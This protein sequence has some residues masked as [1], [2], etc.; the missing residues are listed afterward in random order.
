MACGTLRILSLKIKPY[1]RVQKS[2]DISIIVGKELIRQ[3]KENQELFNFRSPDVPPLLL[4]IDRKDDPVTPLLTQWTYQAMVHEMLGIENNLVDLSKITSAEKKLEQPQIV[5]SAEQDSFYKENMFN[6]FGDLGTSIRN[7]VEQYQIKTKQQT[8]DNKDDMTIEE[9][10]TF[11]KNIP[12]I[13]KL[14]GNVTKHMALIEELQRQVKIRKLL[15]VSELEQQLA[16]V[17]NHKNAVAHLNTMFSRSGEKKINPNELLKLVLLYVLRYES[18][19]DNKIKTFTQMLSE[20]L[21]TEDVK[22]VKTIRNYAGNQKRTKTVDLFSQSF[23]EQAKS[24]TK[25]S[26]VGVENVYTQHVPLISKIITSIKNNDLSE[27]SYPFL[28]GAKSKSQQII[29]FI[30]G[31]VTYEEAAYVANLNRNSINILLGGTHILNSSNFLNA[32]REN[33][34]E[35]DIKID[36]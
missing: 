14:G 12:D 16:C 5:L 24:L 8:R 18:L 21:P 7:L 19:E 23:F 11:V 2:S 31:G 10:K 9:M 6:N 30:V 35:N 27:I 3:I 25:L 32:L 15:D 28:E 17:E 20:I 1:V 26:L 13:K 33:D 22:L 29:I 34:L 4:I 36:I